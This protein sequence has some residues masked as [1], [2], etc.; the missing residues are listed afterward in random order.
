M[1]F[2]L[3]VILEASLEF[4]YEID[5]INDACCAIFCDIRLD[6]VSKHAEFVKRQT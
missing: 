1:H 2:S 3:H 5:T 4:F 6:M